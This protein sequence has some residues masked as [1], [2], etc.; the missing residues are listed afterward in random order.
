MLNSCLKLNISN[1]III[2]LGNPKFVAKVIAKNPTIGK[3]F[4][5]NWFTDWINKLKL[6]RNHIAHQGTVVL[7][8]LA[9]KPDSEPTDTE[10]EEE[11][12]QSDGYKSMLRVVP[13]QQQREQLEILKQ[14]LRAS[15]LDIVR[16][17]GM[18][19]P[20]EDQ[21]TLFFPLDDIDW[22]YE[23]FKRLLSD[24]SNKLFEYLER[25]KLA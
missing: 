23:N 19:I 3:T 22:N 21:Q 12:K 1:K 2:S 9:L 14:N 20:S 5:E 7:S 11:V 16:D 6:C 10:L 25:E 8:P 13:R 18:V 17:D 4:Q 24:T 15:K